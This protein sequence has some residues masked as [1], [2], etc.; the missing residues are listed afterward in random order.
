MIREME[1]EMSGEARTFLQWEDTVPGD[2]FWILTNFWHFLN[3][4]KFLQF[5]FNSINFWVWIYQNTTRTT[6]PRMRS[7]VWLW[8]PLEKSLTTSSRMQ[9]SFSC[10]RLKVL[11]SDSNL[12]N[13]NQMANQME[14]RLTTSST[15]QGSFSS[16]R[17]KEQVFSCPSSS[18]PTFVTPSLTN[19]LFWIT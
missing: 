12:L 7:F 6:G 10:T 14:S 4:N 2:T 5:V 16:T 8:W 17:F 13:V 11:R 15:M 18:I 9:G 19:S 3:L 1:M